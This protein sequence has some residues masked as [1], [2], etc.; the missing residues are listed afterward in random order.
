MDLGSG[1]GVTP[2]ALG[3]IKVAVTAVANRYTVSSN[4][5]EVLVTV[6]DS[7]TGNADNP[8]ISISGPTSV[9]E[10]DSATYEITASHTPYI[11][12]IEVSVKVAN[13]RGRFL[14]AGEEKIHPVSIASGSTPVT[15]EID[16]VADNPDGRAGIITV[17][18]VDGSMYALTTPNLSRVQTRVVDPYVVSVWPGDDIDES[19]DAKF[20]LSASGPGRTDPIDVR[21]QFTQSGDFITPSTKTIPVTIYTQHYEPINLDYDPEPD[22]SVT[23]TVLPPAQGS[24]SE[25][26]PGTNS[27]ATVNVTNLENYTDLPTVILVN[28]IATSGV[29][30]GH[31]FEIL[32]GLNS[33]QDTDLYIP[34]Q[35]ETVGTAPAIRQTRGSIIIPAN[36]PFATKRISVDS[37]F[38]GDLSADAKY[39]VTLNRIPYSFK[40]G[41]QP[42]EIEIP[43]WDNS[44]PTA[45]RPLI[46]LTSNNPYGIG[47]G[48]RASFKLTTTPAP[49][50]N[51]SIN[52]NISAEGEF[53]FESELNSRVVHLSAGDESVNFDVETIFGTLDT[54]RAVI[55]AQL[56]QGNG[57]ILPDIP[58]DYYRDTNQGIELINTSTTYPTSPSEAYVIVE[59]SL[60]VSITALKNTVAEGDPIV[61]RF[62]PSRIPDQETAIRIRITESGSRFLSA[63]SNKITTI[64]L[65]RASSTDVVFNTNPIND[66][67]DSSGQVTV[68]VLDGLG[69]QTA[70]LL[71]DRTATTRIEEKSQPSIFIEATNEF[72]TKGT[73]AEFKVRSDFSMGVARTFTVRISANPT[74]LIASQTDRIVIIDA[75]QKE[76]VFSVPV[77]ADSDNTFERSGTITATILDPNIHLATVEVKGSELKIRHYPSAEIRVVDDD[78]PTGISILSSS[79]YIYEGETAEFVIFSGTSIEY[80]R[81]INLTVND[82]GGNIIAGQAPSRIRLPRYHR[83]VRLRIPTVEKSNKFADITV[84]VSLQSHTTGAGYFLDGTYSSASVAVRDTNVPTLS[85]EESLI[86]VTEGQSQV[87]TIKSDPA[88]LNDIPIK[89]DTNAISGTPFTFT[90]SEIVLNAGATSMQVLINSAENVTEDMVYQISIDEDATTRYMAASRDDYTELHRLHQIATTNGANIEDLVEYRE[91]ID[92]PKSFLNNKSIR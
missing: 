85:I 84:S 41:A 76:T 78:L 25:Y 24:T 12:P 71:I 68:E 52:V 39:K 46:T 74:E 58:D 67:I 2:A 19:E 23:A 60:S 61:M 81:D 77:P 32:V 43:I 92:K 70:Y 7:D 73:N 44:T 48:G 82:G 47:I 42:N 80:H 18:L 83:I 90:P 66:H 72:V 17:S 8:V 6:H 1:T 49:T 38:T 57:Y 13:T 75:N 53:V 36:Q 26:I 89:L 4:D 87:F 79:E 55:L 33:P 64:N 88:P 45:E 40:F 9:Y 30:I 63:E 3:Q 35:I 86:Q 59:Q 29:T 5:N 91:F 27:S 21:V 51:L 37:N 16:T 56:L 28:D 10:G 69:Y 34:Y 22:G 62:I 14:A 11:S 31:S 15:L 20:Y 65:L 50:N 54:E